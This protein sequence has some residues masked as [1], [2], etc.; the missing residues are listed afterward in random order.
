MV[1]H[2]NIDFK[3]L[4]IHVVQFFLLLFTLNLA[5][6]A[7]LD[8]Q[9]R[10]LKFER[11]SLE[12]GLSENTI[13]CILQDSRGFMWFGTLDGLN[14]YDGYTFKTYKPDPEDPHSL[15]D[16]WIQWLYEDRA[17]VMWIGTWHGGLNKFDFETEKFTHY[18]HDPE[19]PYSLGS[20]TIFIIYEDSSNALWVGTRGGGLNRFDRKTERF[21]R[22][23]HDPNNPNSL[24]ENFAIRALMEDSMGILWIG[25]AGGGLNR[26]NRTDETFIHFHHDPSNQNSLSN[27]YIRDIVE[28]HLGNLWIGSREG[29]D[30]FDR[31][32]QSFTRYKH[33]PNNPNSL[34]N[35]DIRFFVLNL[36]SELWVGTRGGGLNKCDLE[37][38]HFVHY[39]HDPADPQSLSSN[40]LRSFYQ[41]REGNLWI[42]TWGGGINKTRIGKPNFAHYRHD[43][44]DS[45]S[46]SNNHVRA[47]HEDKSGELWIG[48]FEGGLN[49]MSRIK[50]SSSGTEFRHYRGI[51]N[52]PSG[53]SNDSITAIHEDHSGMLWVGTFGG[54]LNVFNRESEKFRAYRHDPDDP[55]SLASDFVASIYETRSG[56]LWIAVDSFGLDSFDRA[57]QTFTH[58]RHNPDD[59]NSLSHNSVFNVYEDSE[60][61]LYVGTEQ[62]G[63]NTFN[64][65]TGVWHHYKNDPDNPE[66]L[67]SDHVT[68]IS[69]DSSGTLWIGTASG[70]NRFDTETESFHHYTEKDGLPNVFIHGI[71]ED[72]GGNLWVSTNKGITRFNP[73]TETFRNYDMHDGL[74]SNQFSE[75]AFFKGKKGEMYFAGINGF[76]QF[77]P[78]EL[79]DNPYAPPVAITSLTQGGAKVETRGEVGRTKG[80]TFR[81]PK[82]FF[83]FE[84]AALSYAHPKK[85]HYAYML[86]GFDPDW[87]D[88][89]SNRFGRYTNLPG[90]TYTLRVRGSNNDGVWNEEGAS[91]I[92]TIIPPIWATWWFRGLVSFFVFLAGYI[93]YRRRMSR[94]EAK[95]KA[96]EIQVKE[97]TEAAR[98]LQTALSEVELLKNRLQAENVY[99]QDEIKL[100]HNFANIISRSDALKKVL[101]QVEQV[102]ATD[103]TVLIL[104]ESGTGKEL[105]ARAIH[106]ISK[107][108]DRPLVKVDCAALPP[109]LIESELFGH[110]KGA[111][112]GALFKKV[113]RFELADG[114]T[115]FLDEIG[116][117]PLE[118]QMKLLRI[119]QD[120]E[121]ERL[122]NPNSIN[123]DVRIIAA[124]NR[125]L[126]VEIKKARFRED[127]Y[128][129][130][131]VF[132]IVIPPL[133]ERKEDIPLLI[134]HFTNKH[135]ARIGKKIESIPQSVIDTLQSYDWPGNIRELENTI[136]R[137][138]IISPAK[139]LVLGDWFSHKSASSEDSQIPTLEEHERQYISEVLEKTSWRVSGDRG[140][141]KILGMNP[142]TLVSRMKKLGIERQ[143]KQ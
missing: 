111:F 23:Q 52:N 109:N 96:L 88:M 40:I 107:R 63:L 56:V 126:E 108:K 71:L 143:P 20:N 104:G 132:P 83:E 34:N 48:T 120:G 13:N 90:G 115:I 12:E 139:K 136:E 67:S 131:N 103:S 7:N 98:A 29:V 1:T 31:K 35:N 11:I 102:A 129:R 28:D 76:N 10:D 94:I 49:R 6:T 58:Y 75:R 22:F 86:E 55:L 27:D 140:A 19:D 137:A 14:R 33:D 105:L 21:T 69:E 46:L 37:S 84:Y 50:G 4:N 80:I 138:L 101:Q 15:N 36:N 91:L 42:G 141:A 25:T 116:E 125:D 16:N 43:P 57:S 66:S 113:G 121:F 124:T 59:P 44:N 114:G 135:S 79:R 112:T 8:A 82:N 78:D 81:W 51:P 2:R 17:G 133:R 45:D 119:I 61:M 85:N 60:R 110:E 127:L 64:Q 65:Q 117:L 30:R 3:R 97:K 5:F 142:Q 73:R 118:L 54:G 89:G 74:Q 123:V 130:L 100:Q 87:I 62:G 47:I 93:W 26:F 70:L 53:L 9:K 72:S 38:G 24:S 18:T 122:G 68:V 128:Y 39:T 92:I 134:T 95:R 41:D 77:H 32:T 99:L 106:N